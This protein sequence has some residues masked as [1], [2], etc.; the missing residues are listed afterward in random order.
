MFMKPCAAVVFLIST[1]LNITG[2]V[3]L[4]LSSKVSQSLE[5]TAKK[6]INYKILK[7]HHQPGEIYSATIF[8][9]PDDRALEEVRQL[10][11]QFRKAR[12]REKRIKI[13]IIDDERIF[14]LLPLEASLRT[15]EINELIDDHYVGSYTKFPPDT[16][17]LIFHPIDKDPRDFTSIDFHEGTCKP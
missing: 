10:I 4:A 3:P 2:G 7:E 13:T 6:T 9:W 14:L 8:I 5:E 11:C 15:K 1:G 12:H 16:D 17:S